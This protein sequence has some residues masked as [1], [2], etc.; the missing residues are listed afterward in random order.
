MQ[1]V[2]YTLLCLL[3]DPHAMCTKVVSGSSQ[4][5]NILNWKDIIVIGWI[6]MSTGG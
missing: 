6:T 3:I 1:G 5:A 2:L 4:S